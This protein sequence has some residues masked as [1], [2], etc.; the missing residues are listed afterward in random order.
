MSGP[1]KGQLI[2]GWTRQHARLAALVAVAAVAGALAVA[3]PSP[4]FLVALA[5]AIGTI[6]VALFVDGFGGVVVGLVGAAAVI[7]LKQL[8][9]LWTPEGFLISLGS[10]LAIVTGAW[11]AGMVSSDLHGHTGVARPDAGM[12]SAVSGSLGLLDYDL[13]L[14]RLDEE[15]ARATTHHRP[16]TVAVV[17]MRLTDADLDDTARSSAERSVARLVETLVREIDVPFAIGPHLLGV[18]MP[19]SDTAAAWDVLGR[20]I[21]AASDAAFTVRERSERLKLTDFAELHAGI[22]ALSKRVSTAEGLVRAAQRSS[23]MDAGTP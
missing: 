19:E 2:S 23:S 10:A 11:L 21:D 15:I 6:V 9:G 7:A 3:E 22:V 1:G 8:G 4:F 16:L 20:V 17:E 18:I 5:A 14:A 13:A 12:A